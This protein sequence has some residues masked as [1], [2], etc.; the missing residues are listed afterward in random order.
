MLERILNMS[1]RWT[2]RR[3]SLLQLFEAPFALELIKSPGKKRDKKELKEVEKTFTHTQR[4]KGTFVRRF[5]PRKEEGDGLTP[6]F[7]QSFLE[8]KMRLFRVYLLVPSRKKKIWV[9]Q[10]FL[11]LNFLIRWTTFVLKIIRRKTFVMM[12]SFLLSLL[13]PP[14]SSSFLLL[15]FSTE[16]WTKE[17]MKK[18]NLES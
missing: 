18:R 17:T 15:F 9:E 1:R 8:K 2:R 3:K 4:R 16:T 10:S 7:W 14:S 6:T 13:S 5:E 11:L 12:Q